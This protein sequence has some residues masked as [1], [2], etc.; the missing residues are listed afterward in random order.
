MLSKTEND[1]LCRV[2]PGTP[3]GNYLRRF[4]LPAMLKEELPEP[5]GVPVRLR[6]LGEDLIAFRDSN[7]AIGVVANACPHRGAS[8]FFGRN[9][10]AGLRCVYHGWKFDVSGD[11]VDMPNE[12]AES[13]FKHKIHLTAYPATEA[14]SLVWV[15][16]GPAE[17]QP[18]LPNFE[19][20]GIREDW[21][22]TAKIIYECNYV[23]AI[24]GEI[25]TT[26]AAFLHSTLDA[27]Q[28]AK[29]AVTLGGKYQFINKW[30]RFF[31]TQTDFGINVGA[32]RPVGDDMAYWRISQWLQPVFT[33]I[34][35]EP[36][37]DVRWGA[38]VPRDDDTTWVILLKWNPNNGPVDM[39]ADFE[40]K[41]CRNLIPG[42]WRAHYNLGNDY[43]IDRELQRTSRYSGIR[44][45]SGRAEDAAMM[46]SMGPIV[47][48]SQE[49]L[50]TT[51]SAVIAMRRG[52]IRGARA[53]EQGIE[54]F[55]ATHPDVYQVRPSSCYIPFN[56]FYDQVEDV[57]KEIYVNPELWEN[58]VLKTYAK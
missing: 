57:R 54:P 38:W 37:S 4:W 56:D 11:C 55:A 13:N 26:H 1:Y 53:L 28:K 51:D 36:G 16:M 10:E 23:Q 58:G 25:D 40:L 50:G 42:T 20:Q 22:F 45:D 3:M 5:D 18:P 49:H 46:E 8:L 14:G 29:T 33:L 15:Y 2:G 48:R 19:F 9:E 43:M 17:L 35:R 7:G 21:L 6:L 39:D 44:Q 12:P 32:Q 27:A 31:V 30:A 24:E 34:P 47:N 52:L 41:A